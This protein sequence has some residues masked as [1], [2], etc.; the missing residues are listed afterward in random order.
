MKKR[1]SLIQELKSANQIQAECPACG[2]E[3]LLSDAIIFDGAG[4]L[5]DAANS[6]VEARKA[7]LKERAEDLK[8]EE[9]RL[10]KRKHSATEKSEKQAVAVTMGLVVEKII[11]GWNEF[12]HSPIDCKPLF[13]PIDYIAF[14]GLTK[15]QKV[16]SIAFMDIKTGGARLN[17]NQVRVR[18][19]IHEGRVSYREV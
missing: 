7:D 9:T 14:D 8:E 18:D 6:V 1:K 10:K 17:K 15:K 12:P 13:E 16:E 11:T 2:E 4:E 5:P 3:F 19:A